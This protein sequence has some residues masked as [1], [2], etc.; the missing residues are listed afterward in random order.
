M[1]KVLVKDKNGK[2]IASAQAVEVQSWI[3]AAVRT[4]TWGKPERWQK[5]YKKGES[6]PAIIPPY[7]KR[8]VIDQEDRPDELDPTKLV[9]W[10]K[11]RADYTIEVTDITYEHNLAQC[12]MKR[13]E[14]YPTFG[15]F[16]NA[17]FDG[18]PE[19]IQALQDKRLEVKAMYPK[20]EKT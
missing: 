8:D 5:E 17:F 19:E 4:N 1:F 7:D 9:H 3:D 6:N 2:E 12:Y 13:I 15:D 10:V 20:P 18:G 14:N 11:L 16:L